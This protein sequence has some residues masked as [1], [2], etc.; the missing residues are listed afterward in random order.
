MTP[1]NS[2]SNSK[3]WVKAEQKWAYVA[4]LKAFPAMGRVTPSNLALWEHLAAWSHCSHTAP[5]T[6]SS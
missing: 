1:F 6:F 4:G 3:I 5:A 2:I